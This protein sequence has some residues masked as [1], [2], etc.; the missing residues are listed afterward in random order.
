MY[1]EDLKLW[2]G[3]EHKEEKVENQGIMWKLAAVGVVDK[4]FIAENW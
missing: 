2:I 3:Y 4:G 1:S